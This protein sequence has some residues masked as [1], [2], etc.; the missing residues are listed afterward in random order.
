[1]AE[2]VRKATVGW[3]TDMGGF[4]ATYLEKC[5]YRPL[6]PPCHVAGAFFA[7]ADNPEYLVLFDMPLAADSRSYAKA[8]KDL[9]LKIGRELIQAIAPPVKREK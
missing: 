8:E 1:M 5:D 3:I 2:S 6:Q 4:W 9:G 7:P